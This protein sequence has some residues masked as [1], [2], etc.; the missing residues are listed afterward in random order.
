MGVEAA[1]V[2]SRQILVEPVPLLKL[3]LSLR[4][5]VASIVGARLRER[6][7]TH[8]VVTVLLERDAW[9][10]RVEPER[11]H[12]SLAHRRIEEEYR[13]VP[14]RGC[15]FRLLHPKPHVG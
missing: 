13:T 5:H 7:E 8:F 6:L 14:A 1:A 11:V 4:Q 10:R 15:A 2:A 9:P 12:A 3:G